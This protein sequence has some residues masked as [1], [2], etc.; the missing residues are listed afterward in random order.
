MSNKKLTKRTYI[1]YCHTNK[2]NG[3]KYIGITCQKP[4]DRWM[5]GLG[6]VNCPLMNRA[7]KK[8]GWDGFNHDILF[9]GLNKEE[10]EFKEIELIAELD[11]TNPNKGYN[12]THGGECGIPT[13]EVRKKMSEGKKRGYKE[14]PELAITIGKK[15]SEWCKNHPEEIAMMA[16]AH[17]E[18]LAKRTPEE[19]AEIGAKISK[20]NK[21]R[22][23]SEETRAKLRESY[24]TM[25]PETKQK[26]LEAVS[27][28]VRCKTLNIEF[29]SAN[30]A[31][32]QLEIDSSSIAKACKGGQRTAGGYHWEYLN[33]D[34]T[35]PE[36]S[37][38][39]PINCLKPKKPVRCIE[40][41]VVYESCS[42]AGRQLE[43][44]PSKISMCCNGKRKTT[45]GFHWEYVTDDKPSESD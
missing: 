22:V 41:G 3:K 26:K 15:M 36:V 11:T 29:P 16:K 9:E 34:G 18:T 45:G 37:Y 20:A 8:Y 42:E 19:W 27:V 31:E 25:S 30:E 39:E 12:L 23:I 4:N 2:I 10:A 5:N 32:I 7:I 6:Y 43:T 28:P 24:A 35:I 14:N 44:S 21:G 17:H 40:T 33:E 13:E 1:V 38:R